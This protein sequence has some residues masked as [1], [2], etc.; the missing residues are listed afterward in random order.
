MREP[1]SPS[2]GVPTPFLTTR[3]GVGVVRGTKRARRKGVWEVRVYLGRDPL[4]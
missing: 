2:R 1:K 4:T 3:V